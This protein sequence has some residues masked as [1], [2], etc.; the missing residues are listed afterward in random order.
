MTNLIAIAG[1]GALGA[2]LRYLTSI[3]VY[4]LV[5]QNFPYGTLTVN[6]L[7][8][9]LIGFCA[10]V[11]L[12]RLMVDEIWRAILMIGFLGAFTTF[13]TFSLETL[14]LFM[15]GEIF[16]AG[17]NILLSVTL[18]IIATWLGIILGRQL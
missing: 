9:L 2:V 6:V 3:G 13:S 17:L 1:G 12:E 11:L 8:S 7:G 14:N 15:N 10:V 18:C 5:G 16:K 4:R